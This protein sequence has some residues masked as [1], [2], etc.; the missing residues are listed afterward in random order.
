[1]AQPLLWVLTPSAGIWAEESFVVDNAFLGEDSLGLASVT[2]KSRIVAF[3]PTKWVMCSFC[4]W[5]PSVN[6]RMQ[7]QLAAC[8]PLPR[9]CCSSHRNSYFS[10]SFLL[11]SQVPCVHIGTHAWLSLWFLGMIAVWHHFPSTTW[12]KRT[13]ILK[14]HRQL[15][16]VYKTSVQLN[17]VC[18]CET[19]VTVLKP[20]IS[21]SAVCWARWATSDQQFSKSIN[22]LPANDRLL[23]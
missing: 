8:L 3:G 6:T 12:L 16:Y 21:P 10:L 11:P 9:S 5:V 19:S 4:Q 14:E 13:R 22:C 15:L 18:D 1:M 20:S 17:S 2:G 23:P 7:R